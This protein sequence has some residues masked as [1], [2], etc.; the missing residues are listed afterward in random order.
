MGWPGTGSSPTGA[1]ESSAVEVLVDPSPLK[2]VSGS[3]VV[4]DVVALS[5]P[6][7]CTQGAGLLSPPE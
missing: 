4:L 3:A 5:P 6:I 7:G 1:V 2:R